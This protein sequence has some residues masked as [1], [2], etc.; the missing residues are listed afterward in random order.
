[1]YAHTYMHITHIYPYTHAHTYTY[2]KMHNIHTIKHIQICHNTTTNTHTHTH[3]HRYTN[4]HTHAIKT[5]IKFT[6]KGVD[7]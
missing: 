7:A 5:H 3:I 2:A 4:T 1:M 6:H